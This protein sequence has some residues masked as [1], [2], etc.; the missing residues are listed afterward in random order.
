MVAKGKVRLAGNQAPTAALALNIANARLA[1]AYNIASDRAP[2]NVPIT[3]TTQLSIAGSTLDLNELAGKVAGTE[4]NGRLRVGLVS[5][6]S[7]TGDLAVGTVYLP[8]FVNAAIGAPPPAS[9]G[10]GWSPEPFD[11]GVWSNTVIGD[12]ALRFGQVGLTPSLVAHD[13]RAT[14]SLDRGLLAIQRIDGT[15]ADGRVAGSLSFRNG[16]DG[17]VVDSKISIAGADVTALLPSD[18][19]LSGHATFALS[20]TGTGRSPIALIGSL[21]GEGGFTLQDGKIARLDPGAFEAVT[22][23]VDQGLPIDTARIRDRLEKA[24]AAG[25]LTVSL[26]RG[27]IPVAGGQVRLINTAVRANRADLAVSGSY[28]SR[29]RHH[30]CAAGDVRTGDRRRAGG[31]PSRGRASRCAGRLPMRG[32]RSTSPRSPICWR[33]A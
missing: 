14:L 8:A 10:R 22:R 19:A 1:R 18:N 28:R 31:G 17:L 27:E 20:A 15:L 2:E 29:R 26:V 25:A 13:V 9:S 16:P 5:P 33:C 7:V 11:T 6:S 12:V 24:F 4:I 21:R 32:A 30:R 23:S 3:L